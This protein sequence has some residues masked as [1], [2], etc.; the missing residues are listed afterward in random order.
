LLLT[1]SPFLTA[2]SRQHLHKTPY[3]KCWSFFS[4]HAEICSFPVH[5]CR[6]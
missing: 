2:V 1:D 4:S 3:L 5:A 6:Q